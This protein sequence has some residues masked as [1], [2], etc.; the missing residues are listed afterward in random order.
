MYHNFLN[1]LKGFILVLVILLSGIKITAQSKTPEIDSLEN[2]LKDALEKDRG[3]LLLD[4]SI[5][6]FPENP[7]KSLMLL[8]EA[9]DLALNKGDSLLL[10]K[11][12]RIKGQILRRL[13]RVNESLV[14]LSEV[15]PVAK[16][17]SYVA[18]HTY[19]LNALAIAFTYQAN[20]DKALLYHFE[21]L[22]IRENL[23]DKSEISITLHNIGFV[24]FK[25]KNYPEALK[26]YQRSLELK[27]E[28]GDTYDLDRLLIN[29]GLCHNQ[30]K[31]Y[32][33]AK[34]NFKRAFEACGKECNDAITM[35]GL[36]G[37]GVA[38]YGLKSY[39]E[40]RDHFKE[41][42]NLA[43]QID[44]KRFQ[45]ENQVYL[46]RIEIAVGNFLKA[47][48][49]L[50]ATE[51]IA[52]GTEYNQL[53][54][55]IYKTFSELHSQTR[56]F[57]KA[58]FYQ[59]KYINLKD[60]IYSEE[61]I[62]N[63]A[64]VQADYA[65]RENLK[66]IAAKDQILI[67]KEEALARQRMFNIAV[68]IIAVLAG[69]LVFVFYRSNLVTRRVN[70]ALSEAKETIEI[71]NRQLQEAKSMLEDKVAQRTLQ[72]QVANDS[73]KRVNEELDN[74]IYKT[75]HDIRGPLA[76]L[77]GICN[78]AIMDV[79]DPI[80]L[81][82]LHKLDETATKLNIVLTRL[83]I[84]NQ[85]NNTILHPEPI[86]FNEI[87]D[88]V[89]LLERKKG[90]PQRLEIKRA[91]DSSIQFKSDNALIRIVLEN[92]IDNA[93]KFHNDSERVSPFVD[94]QIA[95]IR[96]EDRDYLRIHVID[97]GIGV[98]KADPD[99]IFQM[100]SR[101][102]ERSGLGGI[103]LYLSK[104]ATE[105]LGGSINLRTTPEGYTDFFVTFPLDQ[106]V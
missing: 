23:G 96:S 97:N 25:L 26:Y 8:N 52:I 43:I 40:A 47:Q 16:R 32:E 92:L 6:Y 76:S 7:E 9:R 34:L 21:S 99:K 77:K 18:D 1:V 106:P 70:A 24:Y 51:A 13:D 62:K 54:I 100:F 57:E 33:E 67:A 91:I 50:M 102:S 87:V 88:D 38:A 86:N 75:S 22:A 59:N 68:V 103:G 80:A 46:G 28:S 83:L 94:I 65:E 89:V 37:L 48:E 11:S 73:L 84:I 82:Y 14:I 39:D 55:D 64:Q 49:I 90:M 53:L 15:L 44:N 98:S 63:L 30:V 93:I 5:A 2:L 69:L 27:K 79:K 104:L 19:I 17:N 29:I 78:V 3:V 56:E 74:F 81:D 42:N 10:V 61:L 58:S 12:G 60:S 85:I 41:S 72:L 4:L 36:F 20:Y 66:T 101:A 95:K 31:N 45:L 35:E 71:Q 105:K